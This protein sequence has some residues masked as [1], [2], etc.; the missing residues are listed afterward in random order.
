MK[1][2]LTRRKPA[3]A[4][5]S[6]GQSAADRGDAD[7]EQEK[8]EEHA[9]QTDVRRAE[10]REHP[11]EQRQAD[12]SEQKA[13]EHPSSSAAARPAL[14]APIGLGRL[15]PLLTADHVHVEADAGAPD[16]VVDH[17]PLR[18]LAPARPARRAEHD[19][20]RV[21]RPRRVEQRLA[22]VGADDLAVG[23]AELLDQPALLLEER[24]GLGCEPVLRDDVDGDEL[25]VRALG[26]P[27]RP[28]DQPL[29]VGR[30]GQRDEHALARLPR[31]LDAVPRAVRLE[32]LVDPVG[33]P[34]Q[35][36]LAE[37]A[38]VAGPEVVA[39]RRV[40]PLGGVDVAAGEPRADRLDGEVDELELVG[41]PHDLVGDRLALLD[42]R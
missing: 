3:T 10:W 5:A 33:D 39:E 42:A 2:Q 25:A 37:R 31:L 19:L 24:G 21:Q 11:G 38:E 1:Y 8:E 17:R 16:H 14:A 13:G 15:C 35:R 40:D 41:A 6:A 26:H 20:G 32:A 12:R 30:A 4:A 34:E 23:A 29:A 18:Q 22:D 7:D 9:R 36:E 28:P 27:C